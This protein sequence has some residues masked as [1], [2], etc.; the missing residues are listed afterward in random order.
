MDRQLQPNPIPQIK[1]RPLHRIGQYIFIKSIYLSFEGNM[2]LDGMFVLSD[3]RKELEDYEFPVYIQSAE[4]VYLQKQFGRYIY[5]AELTLTVGNTESTHR[6]WTATLICGK[7]GV[8]FVTLPWSVCLCL[9]L[10]ACKKYPKDYFHQL[11][12]FFGGSTPSDP[13]KK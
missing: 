2:R 5:N 13:R 1:C 7:V 8:G 10:S 6:V 3:E 12:A 9:C 11:T 4:R